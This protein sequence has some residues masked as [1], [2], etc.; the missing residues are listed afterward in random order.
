MAGEKTVHV[1]PVSRTVAVDSTLRATIGEGFATTWRV[2][3]HRS[4]YIKDHGSASF[5]DDVCI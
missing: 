5:D 2:L 3:R 4:T 1:D